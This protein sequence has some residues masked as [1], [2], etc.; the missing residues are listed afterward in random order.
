MSFRTYLARGGPWQRAS[1]V[2]A[3]FGWAYFIQAVPWIGQKR[4]R[5]L[6]LSPF[7]EVR[8]LGRSEGSPA[9]LATNILLHKR[10][11]FGWFGSMSF[12]DRRKQVVIATSKIDSS[13]PLS[14]LCPS[15]QASI[16]IDAAQMCLG[17]AF[18]ERYHLKT[19]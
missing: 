18:E 11:I 14:L 6:R 7:E 2:L 15:V 8:R 5:G 3:R 19:G 17:T 12:V 9:P 1:S 16:S 13:R 10:I 4:R